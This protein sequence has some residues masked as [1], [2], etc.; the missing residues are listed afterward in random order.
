MSEAKIPAEYPMTDQAVC[1]FAEYARRAAASWDNADPGDEA[2]AGAVGGVEEGIL[3]L[4]GQLLRDDVVEAGWR[5]EEAARL[6]IMADRF[7]E[8]RH[9][10]AKVGL[11]A[12]LAKIAEGAPDV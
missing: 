6:D 9:V 10:S 2:N 5:A 11:A 1:E 3:F 4:A 8:F 7:A 12:M